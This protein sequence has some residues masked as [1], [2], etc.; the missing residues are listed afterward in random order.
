MSTFSRRQRCGKNLLFRKSIAPLNITQLLNKLRWEYARIEESISNFANLWALRHQVTK[1]ITMNK[2]VKLVIGAGSTR[3]EGWL[4][5]DLPIFN[6]L[7]ASH[8]WFVFPRYSVDRILA[9]HVI[10]HWTEEQFRKFLKIAR[11]FLSKEAFFRL[12]VPDGFHPYPEY[13]DWVRPRGIGPG[14]DDHNVLYNHVL[15]TKI[16]YEEQY[17][18]RLLEYFDSSGQFH[19]S[20]WDVQ[21]GFIERSYSYDPRNNTR[22]L[23]YTS[24]ILDAWPI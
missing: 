6:A 7:Y 4:S 22:P 12:A 16:L 3:F 8:W 9:E 17:D 10:E 1:L 19:C 24:L 2:S 20:S 21:D 23:N 14:A 18:Y 13:I 11:Q 5:T 15:I